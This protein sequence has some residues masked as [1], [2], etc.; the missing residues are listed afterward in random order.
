MN[1]IK[2][3][4]YFDKI[5]IINLA[6]RADRRKEMEAQLKKVNLSLHHPKVSLYSAIKPLEAGEFPS[7]GA[8]GCFLSHFG[9]LQDAKTQ[10]YQR[11]LIFED[12]LDF[13]KDFIEKSALVLSELLANDWHIFY[14]DHRIEN[15]SEENS[16][17]LKIV[18]S[19]L[20][21]VTSNFIGFHAPVM[22]T[23]V[24]YLELMLSRSGG[25]PLGGP[26]HVDGAYTWFRRQHQAFVTAIA[27]PQLGY[28]RSSAS[29]IAD[30]RWI[31]K[32]PFIHSIRLIKKKIKSL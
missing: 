5:Y 31:E 18:N 27:T 17:P 8:R 13:N 25:D 20:S 11:I 23:I 7:I 14:G 26:M 32:I 28:Q 6:S 4:D 22:D 2:F 10:K 30:L 9:I 1:E 29:D 3:F 24:N 12:D 16:K 21:I 15:L 19:D